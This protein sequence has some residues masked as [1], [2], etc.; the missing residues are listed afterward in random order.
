[1]LRPLLSHNSKV[2]FV[3]DREHVCVASESRRIFPIYQSVHLKTLLY[4]TTEKADDEMWKE[5]IISGIGLDPD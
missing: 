4:G 2:T 5:Q 3:G 1:M